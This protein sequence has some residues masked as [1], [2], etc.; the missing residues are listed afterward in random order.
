MGQDTLS[1][2]TEGRTPP[3]PDPLEAG[4]ADIEDMFSEA[5]A[6]I[7]YRLEH[8]E[9]EDEPQGDEKDEVEHGADLQVVDTGAALKT[10]LNSA[11]HEDDDEMV[12]GKY[13]NVDHKMPEND[14]ILC[15]DDMAEDDEVLLNDHAGAE[16]VLP[17]SDVTLTA[18]RLEE[19]NVNEV[20]VCERTPLPVSEPLDM[21][22][23]SV[24]S[25]RTSI[26]SPQTEHS[27]EASVVVDEEEGEQ[28]T[29]SSLW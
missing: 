1:L 25:V 23:N 20:T 24:S 19:M 2:F 10:S 16:E 8:P 11:S 26:F 4:L 14:G 13:E 22:P 3:V 28:P 27:T 15:D 17:A 7:A 12:L 18:T 21:D 29:R 6:D 9:E 5:E